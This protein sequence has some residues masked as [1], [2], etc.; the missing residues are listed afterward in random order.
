MILIEKVRAL[1]QTMP[2]YK[3]IVS[4]ARQKKEQEISMIYG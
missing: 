4:D 2:K 3:E 1:C